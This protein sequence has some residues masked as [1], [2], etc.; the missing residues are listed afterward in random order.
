MDD[1]QYKPAKDLHLSADGVP[2][3]FHDDDLDRLT[4]AH[5]PVR[6]ILRACN[7]SS[8]LESVGQLH[9]HGTWVHKMRTS[10]GVAVVEQVVIVRQV[11]SREAN[12]ELLA[13]GFRNC[14]IEGRVRR[15]V[16]RNGIAVAIQETRTIVHPKIGRTVPG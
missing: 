14:Q 4:E 2:I 11:E 7:R 5:G 10:K 3:V 13:K 6:E 15:Q 1:W 16:G 8:I 9:G 12:R